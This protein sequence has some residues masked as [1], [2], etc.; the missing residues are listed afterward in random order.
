MTSPNECKFTLCTTQ[1]TGT[2]HRQDQILRG[3]FT[4]PLTSAEGSAWLWSLVSSMAVSVGTLPFGRS[5][6]SAEQRRC[7]TEVAP[8]LSLLHS[9]R[10]EAPKRLNRK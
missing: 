7:C 9:S 8:M 5:V 10:D 2:S 4:V 3:M 1:L 6:A